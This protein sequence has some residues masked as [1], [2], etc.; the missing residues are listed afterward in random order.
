MEMGLMKIRT[1][2]SDGRSSYHTER[3]LEL[4]GLSR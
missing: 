4:H 2:M 1:D 3:F